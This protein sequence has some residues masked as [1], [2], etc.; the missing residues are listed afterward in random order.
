MEVASLHPM[1][2]V[3]LCWE[4]SLVL[5]SPPKQYDVF[6]LHSISQHVFHFRHVSI[7]HVSIL[8][9]K[10]STPP[11]TLIIIDRQARFF[12]M[13]YLK[14]C[15]CVMLFFCWIWRQVL[16]DKLHIRKLFIRT[17]L[18]KL[19]NDKTVSTHLLC[20][21]WFKAWE[22]LTCSSSQCSWPQTK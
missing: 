10:I 2:M 4:S 1:R 13:A 3:L 20:W 8:S 18:I 12:F 17:C 11:R 14:F 7:I 19:F 22:A 15:V 21:A 9:A 6:C 5:F 16:I